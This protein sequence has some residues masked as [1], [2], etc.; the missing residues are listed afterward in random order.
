MFSGD[1]F[2]NRT[3]HQGLKAGVNQ[4]AGCGLQFECCSVRCPQRIQSKKSAG[5]QRA[6]QHECRMASAQV[7]AVSSPPRR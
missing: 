7:A 3:L 1:V 6:L 5:R 2:I 4:T